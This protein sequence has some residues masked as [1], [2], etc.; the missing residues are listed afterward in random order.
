MSPELFIGG[1]TALEDKPNLVKGIE[2][3]YQTLTR[4]VAGEDENY[5]GIPVSECPLFLEEIFSHSP[6]QN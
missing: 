1:G 2:K 3:I 6:E 5:K 4:S